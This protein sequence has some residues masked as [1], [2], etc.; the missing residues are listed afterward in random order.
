[1]IS[2][3]LETECVWF[4][5][6]PYVP[7]PFIEPNLFLLRA[8]CSRKL[9]TDWVQMISF[10]IFQTYSGNI[11]CMWIDTR[12]WTPLLKNIIDIY[13]NRSYAFLVFN[14]LRLHNINF[15]TGQYYSSPLETQFCLSEHFRPRLKIPSISIFPKLV[16]LC[17]MATA[18]IF[19]LCIELLVSFK[20]L[21]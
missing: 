1:M 21:G 12:F 6:K 17:L 5:W 2:V 8:A 20:D 4:I 14:K 16:H 19:S 11:V 9:S 10:S 3:G 15:D 13:T 7:I 18:Q